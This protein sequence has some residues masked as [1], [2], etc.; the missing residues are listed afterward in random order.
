[1]NSNSNDD[2][3]QCTFCA[4]K[5][6][7]KHSK[8]IPNICEQCEEAVRYVNDVVNKDCEDTFIN[9]KEIQDIDE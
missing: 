4:V 8:R 2:K 6:I 5:I 1:M 3:S 7:A 9:S